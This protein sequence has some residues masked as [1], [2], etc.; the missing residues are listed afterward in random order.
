MKWGVRRLFLYRLIHETDAHWC[1]CVSGAARRAGVVRGHSTPL[2]PL[3]V[4]WPG[5]QGQPLM[6]TLSVLGA[7]RQ[8]LGRGAQ[9]A[10]RRDRERDEVDT[11]HKE[12]DLSLRRYIR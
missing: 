7:L 8:H 9:G 4:W 3:S 10:E 12:R 6:S 2:P 5:K 1:L 11:R